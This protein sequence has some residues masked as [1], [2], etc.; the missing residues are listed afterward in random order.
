MAPSPAPTPVRTTSIQK[1]GEPPVWLHETGTLGCMGLPLPLPLPAS[2]SL[3]SPGIGVPLRAGASRCRSAAPSARA[4]PAG[5]TSRR[6]RAF[7]NAARPE[8]FVTPLSFCKSEGVSRRHTDDP[9][10][11]SRLRRR[12]SESPPR[13]RLPESAAL[14]SCA[15]SYGH[16]LLQ[17]AA[18]VTTA[19]RQTGLLGPCPNEID[20]LASVRRVV[21]DVKRR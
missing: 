7:G 11:G 18:P 1:R 10:S 21:P 6:S 16:G 5:E 15:G 20:D 12:R 19:D 3:E 4:A 9:E 8:R 13:R 2:A 14:A 17:V